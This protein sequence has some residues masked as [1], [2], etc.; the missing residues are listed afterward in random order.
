MLLCCL[1][2][3]FSLNVLTVVCVCGGGGG[4]GGEAGRGGGRGGGSEVQVIAFMDLEQIGISRV[5]LPYPMFDHTTIKGDEMKL[6]TSN[7]SGT[8]GTLLP[9]KRTANTF[10]DRSLNSERSNNSQFH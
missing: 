7:Q 6:L 10:Y 5:R 3:T 2:L 8:S 1:T 9:C 4:G